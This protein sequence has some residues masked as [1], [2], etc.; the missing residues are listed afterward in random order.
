MQG[1]ASRAFKALQKWYSAHP[2]RLNL[3]PLRKPFSRFCHFGCG[4]GSWMK[5]SGWW[6]AAGFSG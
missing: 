3:G 4:V 5:G 6:L 2:N 1:E